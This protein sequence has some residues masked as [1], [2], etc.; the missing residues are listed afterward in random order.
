MGH[1]RGSEELWASDAVLVWSC[2]YEE[3]AS[4][5]RGAALACPVSQPSRSI[6]GKPTRKLC[7]YE[8]PE[9]FI[10]NIFLLQNSGMMYRPHYVSLP[11][12]APTTPSALEDTT[13][14]EEDTSLT[15]VK[16]ESAGQVPAT[17][18]TSITTSSATPAS[19][20]G[21]GGAMGVASQQPLGSTHVNQPQ[22]SGAMRPPSSATMPSQVA[23]QGQF[24]LN[25]GMP[26]PGGATMSHMMMAAGRG[27]MGRGMMGGAGGGAA[28]MATINRM[29]VAQQAAGHGMPAISA[30]MRL[31]QIRA[32]NLQQQQQIRAGGGQYPAGAGPMMGNPPPPNYR[33]PMM[34][35]AAGG[36]PPGGP[37]GMVTT[38]DMQQQMLLRHQQAQRRMQ[39]HRYQQLQMQ[40][41]AA[42]MQQMAAGVT[43]LVQH[44]ASSMPYDKLLAP[45][46][47]IPL[48]LWD[49]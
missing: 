22:V 26:R 14:T 18:S 21:V 27:A 40:R 3:K 44:R 48:C 43:Q 9:A 45:C 35:P 8:S 20:T 47:Q 31:E 6:P 11:E 24:T 30:R 2:P 46:R 17:A 32:Q 4:E 5:V 38:H 13:K 41:R 1:P 29:M 23:Q 36:M 12:A 7:I 34:N 10:H 25:P 39:M 37:G 16:K 42:A 15:D 19:T 49:R 33:S 28:G